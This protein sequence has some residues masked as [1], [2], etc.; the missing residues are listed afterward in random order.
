MREAP[1]IDIIKGLTEKGAKI[2]AYD[3][4]AME[5]AKKIFSSM[6]ISDKITFCD[7]QYSA[8]KDTDALVIVTEWLEFRK[9]DFEK[10]KKSLKDKTIFD[11]RNIYKPEHMQEKGFNY[12]S[13]GRKPV[14]QK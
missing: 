1:A 4:V 14:L 13:I 8:L 9:P 3:P 5:N 7:N 11:G 2:K 10:M 6:G 12:F